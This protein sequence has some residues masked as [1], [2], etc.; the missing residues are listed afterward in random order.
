MQKKLQL[1]FGF[2]FCNYGELS[3]RSFLHHKNSTAKGQL[4]CSSLTLT[5]NNKMHG[6]KQMLEF[7]MNMDYKLQP[8]ADRSDTMTLARVAF[9]H[10]FTLSVTDL[11]LG[12]HHFEYHCPFIHGLSWSRGSLGSR[13]IRCVF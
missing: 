12:K 8:I 9:A 10:F 6:L 13:S 3:C 11:C 2:S 5:H 7:V 4:G 1:T